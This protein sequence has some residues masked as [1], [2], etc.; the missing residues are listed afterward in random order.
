MSVFQAVAKSSAGFREAS[1]HSPAW[2]Q[3]S[4]WCGHGHDLPS[5]QGISLHSPTPQEKPTSPLSNAVPWRC[6]QDRGSGSEMSLRG[7]HLRERLLEGKTVPSLLLPH[8]FSSVFPAGSA[9]GGRHQWMPALEEAAGFVLGLT[10][11]PAQTPKN[12]CH[13]S[14]NKSLLKNKVLPSSLYNIGKQSSV[15]YAGTVH[16]DSDT[17]LAESCTTEP[18]K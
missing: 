3:T 1:R 5:F 14:H 17:L 11:R 9:D 8:T 2:F 7:C 12:H 10:L 13:L 15:L 18:R 6:R 4:P 16:V